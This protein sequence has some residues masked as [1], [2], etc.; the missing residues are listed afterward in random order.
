MWSRRR[1]YYSSG[2]PLVARAPSC[3]LFSLALRAAASSQSQQ[4]GADCYFRTLPR[5]RLTYASSSKS[6]ATMLPRCS[7]PFVI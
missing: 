2:G 5:T 1:A 4:G 6:S 3:A 7:E